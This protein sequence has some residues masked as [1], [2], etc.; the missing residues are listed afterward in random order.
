MNLPEFAKEVR[1][2]SEDH[3]WHRP[4]PSD[5][6]MIAMIHS[7]WSEALDAYRNKKDEKDWYILG[8]KPEGM[9]VELADGVIRILDMMGNE[10]EWLP[11]WD[12][13]ELPAEQTD[14]AENMGWTEDKHFPDVIAI[15]HSWTACI[16]NNMQS[17]PYTA[18]EA[19]TEILKMVFGWMDARG[20]N[21]ADILKLKHAYNITR[22][23]RHGGKR[24]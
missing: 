5:G 2:V 15:L 8:G 9:A 17:K 4:E 18:A 23:Y 19:M 22:P 7:E 24:C 12:M 10:T 16:Y 6:Q 21:P 20:N 13:D 11:E 1:R 3:G 14:E